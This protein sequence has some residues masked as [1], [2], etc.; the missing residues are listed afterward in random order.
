MATALHDHL[1]L[2]VRC[3]LLKRI[4]RDSAI[5][6]RRMA[7]ILRC[8]ERAVR[9]AVSELRLQGHPIASSPTK[10]EGYYWPRDREE[11]EE[12]SRTLWSRVRAQAEVARAYDR[13]AE[14]LG[15]RHGRLEQVR[16]VF[17]EE[18]AS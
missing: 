4:G 5:T 14:G 1:L 12:C 15:V 16:M 17:G 6:S 9:Q 18:E 3:L 13:A 11:A 8:P 2:S 7:E 10:P